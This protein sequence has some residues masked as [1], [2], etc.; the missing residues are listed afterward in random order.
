MCMCCITYYWWYV[1][2]L[3]LQNICFKSLVTLYSKYFCFEQNDYSGR[4]AV[5]VNIWL[6]VKLVK[7][8][9]QLSWHK[10]I[11][12]N[13][14]NVKA[15]HYRK[16]SISPLNSLNKFNGSAGGF[17]SNCWKATSR[18]ERTQKFVILMGAQWCDYV[19]WFTV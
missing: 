4:C 15:I 12:E 14:Q 16:K 1:G 5:Y 9:L 11:L 8:Q 19:I 18:N 10:Y 13:W 6:A 7:H 2:W 3:D 17:Q